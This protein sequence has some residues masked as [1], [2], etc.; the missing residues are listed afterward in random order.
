MN[1]LITND[2]NKLKIYIEGYDSHSLRAKAYWPKKFPLITDTVES[3]NS[4]KKLFG[5]I[6]SESKPVTFALTFQGTYHTLMKNCG[7][8]QKEAMDIENAWKDM[9]K[10]SMDWVS[11]KLRLASKEG[12][13]TLAFG[14]RLR[15]PILKKIIWQG[16]KMPYEASAEGRSAGNAVSGQSYGQLT[17]RAANEFMDRVKNSPYKYDVKLSAMIHDAIY[18]MVRNDVDVIKWVNDN[19]TECMAW[20]ELPELRHDTVKLNAELDI[21][22]PSWAKG[23]TLPNHS[24]VKQIR[25]ICNAS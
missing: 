12:H 5:S 13:V 2:P 14:L 24:S 7:F 3:V 19:L 8:P 25:E 6:R 17:N 18:L 1:A 23:I 22:Y 11:E 21:F 9:Y 20:Q 16:A 10:V 15:T 4:I